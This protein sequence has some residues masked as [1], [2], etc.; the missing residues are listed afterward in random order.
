M[1]PASRIA[2]VLGALSAPAYADDADDASTGAPAIIVE[3]AP[4]RPTLDA[5]STASRLGLSVRE[6][7]AS[8]ELIDG[9]AIRLRGDR[10]IL[11]AVTRATGVT[12][13]ATP[14]NGGTAL[15]ARGFSGQG[16][17]M[18][19]LDGTRLF[20][21]SGTLTFPFD[22][23]TVDRIEVLRG[24]ASVMY[25]EG[26]IGGAINIVTKRPDPTRP[27]YAGEV[28]AGSFD[29]FRI[30]QCRRAARRADLLSARRELSAQRRLAGSQRRQP[31]PGDIRSLALGCR[32]EPDLSAV[33]RSRDEPSLPLFRHAAGGWGSRPAA[34]AHQL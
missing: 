31:Q 27:R 20:V 3:G 22:P 25:G 15:S 34:P 9:D 29:S 19:L 11:E 13:V 23:W 8:V 5:E 18:Q 17:V 21:G 26:A 33:A 28:A 2:L 6:I 14:G 32:A 10:S 1:L 12:S 30:G 16:S 7:P 4:L 24:P